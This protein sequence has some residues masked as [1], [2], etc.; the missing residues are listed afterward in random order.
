MPCVPG[1]DYRAKLDELRR[2]PSEME[3]V[4][5][6]EAKTGYDFDKLGRCFSALA[7]EANLR[8]LPRA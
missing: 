5:F 6:K 8:H 1:I 7:N 4:E 3:I 2:L